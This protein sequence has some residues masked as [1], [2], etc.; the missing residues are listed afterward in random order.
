[1]V[2]LHKPVPRLSEP[3]LERFLLRAK[4]AAGLRGVV[5]VLLTSSQ[6][7]RSMNKRFRGKDQPTDVLSFP[8]LFGHAGFAGDIAIS[9]DI[10]K[11]NARRLGH[12]A[13]DEVRVLILHGVL[14]L[15]GYDHESD[16]GAMEAQERLLRKKL[17]LPVGLIERGRT[18]SVRPVGA[19]RKMGSKNSWQDKASPTS[20]NGRSAA[21][22]T[23]S[24]RRRSQ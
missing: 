20:S 21:R 15:A 22:G 18:D 4:R 3:S 8:P 11:E 5:N 24:L 12:T 9:A 19:S 17:G 7:L 13:A 2:I 10:A 14:H 16:T 6:E 23:K 1:M